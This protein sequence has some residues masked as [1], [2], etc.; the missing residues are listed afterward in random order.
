MEDFQTHF[1]VIGRK[2]GRGNNS[3]FSDCK[4]LNQIG[5]IVIYPILLTE[6]ISLRGNTEVTVAFKLSHVSQN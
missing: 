3:N 1:N 5:N 4:L 6:S 2:E